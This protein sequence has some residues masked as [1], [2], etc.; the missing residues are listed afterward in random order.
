[1]SR[2]PFQRAPVVDAGARLP[3]GRANH[4]INRV[5]S[6][7]HVSVLCACVGPRQSS[8][9][10]ARTYARVSGASG[11]QLHTPASSA[12]AMRPR[13]PQHRACAHRSGPAHVVVPNGQR[14]T[15]SGG[16]APTS[17]FCRC[18]PSAAAS[19][20]CAA[21]VLWL[22]RHPCQLPGVVTGSMFTAMLVP[23]TA[24]PPRPTQATSSSGVCTRGGCVRAR[25]GAAVVVAGRPEVLRWL[26]E[27]ACA[28]GERD[29]CR[30]CW[31]LGCLGW[32]LRVAVSFVTMYS[33]E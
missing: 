2:G 20:V 5:L 31:R 16:P 11:K 10:C 22:R 19:Y 15:G 8:Y 1:M 9:G 4:Q 13:P 24:V 30:R 32:G 26:R 7:T 3:V 28:W 25:G 21:F 6:V 17:T 33:C 12:R 18:P 27:H 29:V 14:S 23:R